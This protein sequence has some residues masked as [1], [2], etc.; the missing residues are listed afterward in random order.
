M[1]QEGDDEMHAAQTPIERE[2][3]SLDAYFDRFDN[4]P[5]RPKLIKGPLSVAEEARFRRSSFWRTVIAELLT[6]AWFVA[7]GIADGVPVRTYII[8]AVV[9]VATFP[10]ALWVA[11]LTGRFTQTHIG[12][13]V[14]PEDKS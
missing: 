6:F 1:T 3:D 8:L 10:I 14:R 4:P 13:R 5:K 11:R 7:V 9:F 2:R 12:R